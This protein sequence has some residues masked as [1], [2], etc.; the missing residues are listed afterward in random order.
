MTLY[1]CTVVAKGIFYLYAAC[2]CHT[3]TS[4]PLLVTVVADE[5]TPHRLHGSHV[6][7]L[8]LSVRS[9]SDLGRS[10]REELTTFATISTDS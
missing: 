10:D 5:S 7:L 1:L 3:V 6:D 8:A 9:F 4:K 2:K